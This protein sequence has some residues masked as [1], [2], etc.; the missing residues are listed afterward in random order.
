RTSAARNRW[1]GR[2]ST[3]TISA[4][5]T[6]VLATTYAAE[7]STAVPR[8]TVDR[9]CSATQ[10]AASDS[11][12]TAPDVEKMKWRTPLTRRRRAGRPARA[13]S[14]GA[15]ARGGRCARATAWRRDG[16]RPRASRQ[17]VCGRILW[18]LA[19]A[20]ADRASVSPSS[21]RTAR[22]DRGAGRR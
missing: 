16:V 17:T 9:G 4:G 3:L 6:Y 10:I 1:N 11:A 21:C 13:A 15:A 18:D 8:A 19:D 7:T 14:A 12:D 2:A 22:A 20:A 5:T